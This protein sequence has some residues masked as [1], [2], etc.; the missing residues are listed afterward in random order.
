MRDVQW[1]SLGGLHTRAAMVE[2]PGRWTGVQLT[3][4]PVGVRRLLG[5][6]ASEL[7]VGSWDARDLVGDEVDRDLELVGGGGEDDL[8]D[9]PA[10]GVLVP[11]QDVLGRLDPQQV[12]RDRGAGVRRG[13]Q[14]DRVGEEVDRLGEAVRRAV[15]QGGAGR[16]G[17]HP[18]VGPTHPLV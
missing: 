17:L 15:V 6:P 16:H 4:H 18:R 3:L 13:A 7:P 8:A 14:A 2:Q 12:A 10:E 9:P 5:V 11:P 1:V